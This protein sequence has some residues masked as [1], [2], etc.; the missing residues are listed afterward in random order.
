MRK[1]SYLLILVLMVG[2][3]SN[4]TSRDI[5]R[6][7]KTT[8]QVT[9]EQFYQ[10]LLNGN[11]QSVARFLENKSQGRS[12]FRSLG[13]E[14]ATLV[15]SYVRKDSRF[16]KSAAI[17]ARLNEIIDQLLGLQY[18]DGT[19]D[20]GGNRQSPPD[21]GFSLHYLCPAAALLKQANDPECADVRA[22]LEKF[23]RRAGDGLAV[24]GIHT[25]NHRWVVSLALTGCYALYGEARYLHRVDEWL[26]EGIDLDEDGMYSERS[27]NYSEVADNALLNIG[28]ILK[29]P[30]LFGYVKSNL[31]TTWYLME[32]NGDV[33][34]LASRRQDQNF[35]LS[36]TRNYLFYRYLA[37]YLKDNQLA[38]IAWKIETL[39]DF[40]QVI[41]SRS[42]VFYLNNEILQQKLPEIGVAESNFVK[43]FPLTGLVRISQG[44]QSASIF[45]GNDKPVSILSGRSSNPN[46]FTFRKGEAFLNYVRLS[47]SFF[48]MGFF[49]AD[50]F[51]KEGNKYVLRETKEAYYYQPMSEP[52][53]NPKGDYQLSPSMDGRFWSK[54]EFSKRK[55]D[56]KTLN[57]EIAI[58]KSAEGGYNL[59]INVSGNPG[60]FVTLDFC[61]RNGGKLE[62]AVPAPP[63]RG[64]DEGKSTDSDNDYFFKDPYVKYTYGHD[65][66]LVGPGRKEHEYIRG[67]EGEMYRYVNGSNKGEGLHV[68]ITG[69]T[70]FKHTITIR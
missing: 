3:S 29:R 9:D 48:S 26:A 10:Q 33:Q 18:P 2:I 54:L 7:K 67:L 1:H 22:K 37:I 58:E 31:L 32:N 28:H 43:E 44:T 60:V 63:G 50:G 19:L 53:R 36:I 40:S 21:T 61:F 8:N 59:D 55:A 69:V 27:P 38:S 14:F 24:G 30:E 56:T 57:T 45:G 13:E 20:S 66:I 41:L 47:S 52:N 15:A 12:Y 34:T 23:L 17:T 35:L 65:E 5:S 62:G 68:Y 51:K 39:G 42:L 16:F 6:E 70:P 46:F 49:R 25:P 64:Y 11:D 4:L